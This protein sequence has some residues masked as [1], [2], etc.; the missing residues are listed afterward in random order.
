MN[1]SS[2]VSFLVDSL[3]VDDQL[4]RVVLGVGEHFG[5]EE[6]DDVIGYDGRGFVLEIRVVDAEVG[7]EPVDLVGDQ[8]ARDETLM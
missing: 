2:A 3:E 5:A 4:V 1:K 8:F 6:G 7:V